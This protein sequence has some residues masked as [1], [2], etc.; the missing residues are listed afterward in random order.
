[1]D[2][3][4]ECTKMFPDDAV[5]N[6]GITHHY[7]TVGHLGEVVFAV[8]ST[9]GGIEWEKEIA[10]SIHALDPQ[11]RWWKGV[12]VGR[13]SAAIFAVLA[14][15]HIRDSANTFGEAPVPYD[16]GDFGRCKRLIDLF[17]AW[18]VRLKEVADK[19]PSTKWP[20]I[21]ARWDEIEKADGKTQTEILRN[22]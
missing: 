11:M 4:S 14:D 20:S 12:D 1:M 10:E 2:S 13:S 7:N 9:R 6:P 3:L 17:P 8:M 18:R 19:H 22:I 5:V 21:I 16:S 15:D